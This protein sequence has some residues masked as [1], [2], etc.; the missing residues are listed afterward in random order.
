[1]K[2]AGLFSGGKDS[3]WAVWKA[4]QAGDELVTLVSFIS[5]N[6]DSYMFHHVNIRLTELLAETMQVPLI[7]VPTQ[8]KKEAELADIEDVLNDLGPGIE[9][10]TAGALASE[11]QKSRV[12][13]ICDR[14]GL[15]VLAPAW[16]QDPR[17]Y[18]EELLKAGFR[19]IIT[20][21]ACDGLGKEWLGRE[22]TREALEELTALA[23]RHRF[24]L[25][26]E[27]GE[28]ETLVIDCPLFKKRVEIDDAQVQWNGETGSYLITSA[29]LV[30]K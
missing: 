19:V 14:L 22:V 21:V 15:D 23:E 24:H 17:E 4:V 12:E 2:R 16:Q 8:G 1:M 13:A 27:G 20:K 9:G 6:P 30:D 18:W 28:A 11:Y 26:F 25:A 10:V 3:T 7:L 29:K 5:E